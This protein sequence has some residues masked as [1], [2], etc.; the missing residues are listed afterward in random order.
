MGCIS[1]LFPIMPKTSSFQR[2]DSKVEIEQTV[3]LSLISSVSQF[4]LSFH[5]LQH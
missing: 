4:L 1:Y 2:L 3:D 5:S